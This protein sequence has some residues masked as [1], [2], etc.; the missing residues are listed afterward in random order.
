[1]IQYIEGNI[2]DSPAQTI[3]NTVNTVGVMGKG[4]ALSFKERYPDMFAAYR[5]ICE[6]NKLAPGKLMIYTAPD[7]TILLFPT[8]E[9]WR[10]PSKIEYIEKGLE[11][12]VNTYADHNI[13]SI[14]FPRLGC[15]NGELSW[16]DVKPVMERYLAGLPIDVYVYLKNTADPVPEHKRQKSMTQWLKENAKDLSFNAIR[17][18]LM[19]S[20]SLFPYE[21][22]ADSTR[23]T[24]S[25]D[26]GVLIRDSTGRQVFVEENAFFAIWDELRALGVI[27]LSSDNQKNL[28]CKLL[29]ALGY[30]S[31][32]KLLDRVTNEMVP[33]FQVREGLER[34]YAVTGGTA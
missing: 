11:K 33:G 27:P 21:F 12:F 1:M 14:A 22:S 30:L 8:K 9:N 10:N 2:F 25:Y 15:G 23:Y 19:I 6:K 3:V 18:E 24:V 17:D 34:T 32:I 28:I 7:H 13:T 4:L 31:E 29:H 20:T 26:N 16:D 5:S